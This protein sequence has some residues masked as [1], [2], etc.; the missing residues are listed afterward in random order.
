[1]AAA[2]PK[3]LPEVTEQEKHVL[4]HGERQAVAACDDITTDAR[5]TV[6][7]DWYAIKEE[8]RTAAIDAARTAYREVVQRGLANEARAAERDRQRRRKEKEKRKS[9]DDQRAE[10]PVA[11]GSEGG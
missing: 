4:L 8:A 3:W 7:L 1:M 5:A 11:A 9:R 10:V 6:F 2:W